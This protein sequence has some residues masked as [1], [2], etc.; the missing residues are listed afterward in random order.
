M[1]ATAALH[2]TN[3]VVTR[4]IGGL[5][6]EHREMRTPCDQWNVHELIDHMCSGAHGIAGGLQGQAPPEEQ[7]DFLANGPAAG[8]VAAEAALEQVATPEILTAMHDMPFGNVPGEA[9]MAV[10]VSDAATHAWDLA[11]AT[12]Q[13][14][15]MS[16]EL[17]EYALA[18][19]QGLVPAEGRDGG[20]FKA[21][22]PVADDASA[23]D[24]MAGYTGRQP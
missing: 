24:R 6:P 4:L 9:A 17:A 3:E 10:I 16:E 14:L 8:W 19:W 1:D 18:T 12:D 22:V 15:G 20:G 23:V 2:Q 11:K 13:E 7:P 5:T 21:V